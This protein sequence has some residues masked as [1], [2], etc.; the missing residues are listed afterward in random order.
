MAKTTKRGRPSKPE[1]RTPQSEVARA[2]RARKAMRVGVQLRDLKS[3]LERR[4][5]EIEHLT[6]RVAQLEYDLRLEHQHH[7]NTLKEV[8]TLRQQ[9]A[10]RL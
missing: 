10:K 1:G 9:L 6:K 2:Y 5:Q 3:A 7:D 4:D 8:I